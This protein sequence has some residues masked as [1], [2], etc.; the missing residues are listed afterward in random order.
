MK[1]D[2]K[3]IRDLIGVALCALLLALS[4]SAEA[5]Q[6]KKVQRIGLLSSGSPSSTKEGVEA[7]R[8]RLHELGYVE[9]QNIVIEYRYAEGVADRFPNLV[10]E[11]LQLKF[12]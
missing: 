1:H 12:K 4:Y 10:A 9:G 11:L 6:K 5:Q 2:G 3:R 7:F 8:Q